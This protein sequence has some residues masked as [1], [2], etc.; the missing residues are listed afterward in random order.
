MDAGINSCLNNWQLTSLGFS[1]QMGQH[2]CFSSLAF[3]EIFITKNNIK[4]NA[5]DK[6]AA[7]SSY[8]ILDPIITRFARTCLK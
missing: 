7:V 6:K 3:Y 2:S 4:G 1:K 8:E 5:L